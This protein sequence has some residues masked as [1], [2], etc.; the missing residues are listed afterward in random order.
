MDPIN[1]TFP[2]APLAGFALP[3]AMPNPH[4][5]VDEQ[6]SGMLLREEPNPDP[7]N[8]ALVAEWADQIKAAKSFHANAFKKMRDGMD[9]VSG[10]QW[11]DQGPETEL[12]VANIVQRHIQ[13]AVA[14]LYAKNPKAVCK[15]RNTLDFKL[16]DESQ[17]SLM[18]AYLATQGAA[19]AG[20]PVDPMAQALI[21]DVKQGFERRAMLDRVARTLEIVFAY[22]QNQMEPGFKLQ[23][24]QLVRRVLTTGVGYVKVG[25][26]RLLTKRPEDI[27]KI[28]DITQ[29]IAKLERL[30][31]DRIDNEFTE[32]DARHAELQ[33]ILQELNE[34]E[35]DHIAREG[36][37]FDFP[38]ST[39]IIVDPKCRDIR[40]FLGA[41]WIAQEF[42]MSPDDVKEIYKVDVQKNYQQ[43]KPDIMA[44]ASIRL[45]PK[46]DAAK[47]SKCV[48]WE[49]YSKNDG[50]RFVLCDG[51]PDFLEAPDCP[52]TKLE[53]FWPIFCLT[54]NDAEN[55]KRLFPQ[56]DV[57]LLIPM[58]R[59]YNRS[60]QAL[61]E[62]RIANRPAYA[63]P[64]GMLDETDIDKLV[65]RPD[66]AVLM[67]NALAPGQKV[68]DVIQPIRSI[69][70]DPALYDT[71]VIFD[72]VMKVVGGQEANFGG[73]NSATATQSNIAE[74]SRSASISSKVDDLDDFLS[75]I[76]RSAG[77]VLLL[78]MT[79]ET[80]QK[81]AGPGAVWPQASAQD[82]ADELS[83]EIKAGS[84]GRPNR[85]AEIAN[86]QQLAPTLLQMPGIN[87]IWLAKEAIKRMD[88]SLD[89]TEAIQAGVQS[90][91]AQNAQKQ[92]STSPNPEE[93]PNMQGGKGGQ[94][95]AEHM[96]MPAPPPSAPNMGHM[97]G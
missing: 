49:V 95:H 5:E 84:S 37:V 41:H 38:A 8:K 91:I 26:Q 1:P 79:P 93:D 53:R 19:M 83:L 33:N 75:E 96:N 20:M 81:I 50:M 76:S 88:D 27:D 40:T 6:S 46:G 78:N 30:L 65:N 60:R 71:T 48:I 9:F 57:E 87:P 14:S 68:D 74:S 59:E 85:A 90:I 23:M 55:E 56:S 35:E 69:G 66:N 61:R 64:R 16:W 11:R 94:N 34:G 21:D 43:Y 31:A 12:Y 82:I 63:T 25:F 7:A 67:L 72:D 44:Q 54:F 32:T 36:L 45:D 51:Y 18:Q 62:Q 2:V 24:K 17:D 42:I 52:P 73:S 4:P 70:I 97:A 89:L 77:Q 13:Q 39:S 15:R 80:V 28:T 86:F 22:S 58:Q 92:V 3:E 47:G 10:K 29:Q